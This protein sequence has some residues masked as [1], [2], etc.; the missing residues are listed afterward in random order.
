MKDRLIVALDTY[1]LRKAEHLVDCL[2]DTVSTFKIGMELFYSVGPK[3]VEMVHNKGCRVFLD[4]KFHDIPNTVAGAAQAAA[5]LGVFMFNVHAAGGSAMM[6]AAVEAAREVSGKEQKNLPKIIAVTLLTSIDEKT[7]EREIGINKKVEQQVSEWAALAQ[8]SGLAGVVAS[9]REI[10]TIRN[11][12]GREFMIVTPGIRPY[13]AAR[14]DQKRVMTPAEAVKLGADYLV[15]G[16]PITQA[17]DPQEA[18]LKIIR[19]MEEV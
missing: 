4:L 19:E 10:Q 13:W 17:D 15:V 7:L 6:K 8:T 9:P 11:T 1:D 16:R 12:C 14:G 18:A 3:A 5:K 2:K